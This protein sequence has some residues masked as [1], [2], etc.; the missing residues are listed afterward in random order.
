MSA[1]YHQWAQ[2]DMG[3]KFLRQ[4]YKYKADIG[5]TETKIFLLSVYWAGTKWD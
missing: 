5:K 1:L 3:H 4:V 2:R